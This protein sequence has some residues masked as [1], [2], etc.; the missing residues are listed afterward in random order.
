MRTP[1]GRIWLLLES[2]SVK[3]LKVR[4]KRSMLG[5]A[6][7]LLKPVF[8]M[9]V[10]AVVF[11]RIIR[12]GAA[13]P[14]YPLFLMTGLL[15]WN[16]LTSS[17]ISS[18]TCLLDNHRLVRSVRFPRAALPASSVLANA[19][20]MVLALAALEGILI[21]FGHTPGPSLALV[22]AALLFLLLMTT[23]LALLLSVW[24]VYYRDVAQLVEVLLLAWFYGSPVI[25]PLGRPDILP[26][27]V[28]RVIAFNP[29]AGVLEVLHSGMYRGDWPAPWVWLS[30]GAWALVLVA[31]GLLVFR[32]AEPA[33]VKEL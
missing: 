2:L 30:M 23:G 19:A 22:P 9:A 15:A 18:T 7:F 13:I 28:G 17:L 6:W 26:P 3:E 27:E 29:V 24:N 21:L 16:F 14:H 33:V 11:T 25:Y 4:Y 31:A 10:Y 1:A 8:Q 12:F 5:F 32:R 20:H